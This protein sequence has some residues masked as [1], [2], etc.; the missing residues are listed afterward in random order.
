MLHANGIV[1]RSPE[2]QER[3]LDTPSTSKTSSG[4]GNHSKVKKEAEFD[5]DFDDFD[6]D[7]MREK[8]LLVRFY[9]S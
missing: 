1:P 9:I 6:E 4:K 2:P 5:S 8:A 7:S 3:N